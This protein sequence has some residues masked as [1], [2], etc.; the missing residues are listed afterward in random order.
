[1]ECH[2]FECNRLSYDTQELAKSIE[3]RSAEQMAGRSTGN[4]G[5]RNALGTKGPLCHLG[6]ERDSR[7][8]RGASVRGLHEFQT[9]TGNTSTWTYDIKPDG[10]NSKLTLSVQYNVPD[11]AVGR[12]ASG[13]LFEKMNPDRAHEIVSNIK[14]MLESPN[15]DLH[16]AIGSDRK[17]DG[18][19]ESAYS[20]VRES[21]RR[22]H[23]LLCAFI[24][25]DARSIMRVTALAGGTPR[26]WIFEIRFR[27]AS[28]SPDFGL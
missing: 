16:V 8:V 22:R 21:S 28:V 18:Q 4:K 24:I 23:P 12:F 15:A 19:N 27:S 3:C 5:D 1:M 25:A 9:V 11:N 7:S 17:L 6:R 13:A 10:A 20:S 2:G 14:A 26:A